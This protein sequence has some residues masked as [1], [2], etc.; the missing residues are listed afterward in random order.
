MEDALV[1]VRQTVNGFVVDSVDQGGQ[2][3]QNQE[4]SEEEE[5]RIPLKQR[6][7]LHW[8]HVRKDDIDD[9]DDNDDEISEL[10]K[11]RVRR[12][13]FLAHGRICHRQEEFPKRD[14][15]DNH[16]RYRRQEIQYPT[17]GG[18]VCPRLRS[19][20]LSGAS[21]TVARGI[22]LCPRSSSAHGNILP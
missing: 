21:A 12:V 8:H 22:P 16:R 9:A 5:F 3:H 7:L 17:L 13:L 14:E 20:V 10:K 2:R 6:F 11:L 18:S 4:A 15:D 19:A 1:P